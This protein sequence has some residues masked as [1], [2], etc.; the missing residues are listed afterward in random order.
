MGDK[1]RVTRKSE[2]EID[3]ISRGTG[4]SPFTP[5]PYWNALD[6]LQT[7][8]DL[9]G[10]LLPSSNG[11]G[12]CYQLKYRNC[13]RKTLR[14]N[15][16][17]DFLKTPTDLSPSERLKIIS[18]IDDNDEGACLASGLIILHWTFFLFSCFI[19]K[20]F[21]SESILKTFRLS[22]QQELIKSQS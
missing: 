14:Y 7:G 3:A 9:Y 6:K 19:T 1:D 10:F 12:S 4:E 5:F 21:N 11:F 8:P 22:S 16:S 2:L 18:N 17:L 20:C 15:R 13:K